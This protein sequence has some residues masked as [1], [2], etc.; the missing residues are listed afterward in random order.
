MSFHFYFTVVFKD[1]RYASNEVIGWQSKVAHP[2]LEE[3]LTELTR[4]HGAE[5]PKSYKTSTGGKAYFIK[6]AETAM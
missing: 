4:L 6:V 5:T 1:Y 3:F 2:H